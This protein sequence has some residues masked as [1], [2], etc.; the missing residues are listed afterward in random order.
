MKPFITNTITLAQAAADA[1]STP[2]L[3]NAVLVTTSMLGLLLLVLK[4]RES[5]A[6][7][8]DPKFTYATIED[9]DRL[10]N[11]FAQEVRENRK[12]HREMEDKRM[13]S[14]ASIH[15]LVRDNAS[16]IA[17]LIATS[18]YCQQRIAELNIKVDRINER[19]QH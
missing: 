12:E 15:E 8:P 5:F 16:H 2:D 9:L 4:I 13:R 1:P 10:R 18:E 7:K 6:I 17:A 14:L 19:N 11:D 3:G